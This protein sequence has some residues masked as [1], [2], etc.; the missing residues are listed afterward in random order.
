MGGV[1]LVMGASGA[2][3]ARVAAGLEARGLPVRPAGRRPE[4][5]GARAARLDLEDPASFS[6]A[7]AGVD[8]VFLVARPGDD[9]PER[10]ALPLIEAMEGAGV[11]HVVDL[12]AMGTELRP[13]FG[14]RKVELA[15][16]GSAM[17]WTHLRPNWFMEVLAGPGLGAGIRER[18]VF[19]VPTGEAVISYIAAD[20][21]AAVAVAALAEP[22]RHAGEAYTLT[23]PESLDGAAVAAALSRVTSAPVRYVALEEAAARIALAGAGF[24][25]AW[26][27]RLVGFYRLVRAGYAAPVT[28]AVQRVLGRPA[29]T[30]VS[31]LDR[32]AASFG[33]R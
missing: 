31:W 22:E 18:G 10:L 11:R 8:R 16:E 33:P 7:L 4:E 12:S 1:T 28:D 27:E 32:N 26:V 23:G 25:T 3:G 24:P 13:D 20:D 15:L 29:E 30:L 17:T 21:V 6:P 9:A 19:A 14:L 5:L 2:I